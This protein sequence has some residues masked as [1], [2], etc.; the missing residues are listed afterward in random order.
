LTDP[1]LIL[2]TRSSALTQL[3]DALDEGLVF[4][5]QWLQPLPRESA[6][7]EP[8]QPCASNIFAV[9]KL[10]RFEGGMGFAAAMREQ[11]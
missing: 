9:M 11:N 1:D 4:F 3:R 2:Q 10:N 8:K 7:E 5:P 6:Y